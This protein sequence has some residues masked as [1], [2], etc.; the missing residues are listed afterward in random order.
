MAGVHFSGARIALENLRSHKLRTF[1]T[2]LGNIVGTM[3]VVAVVSLIFGADQ[4]ARRTVLD[5]GTD[6]F[7]IVRVNPI[8]FLTDFDEF[9][10]SLNNPNLTLDDRDW[11]R[12]RLTLARAVGASIETTADLRAGRANY[13]GCLVR[14]K[15]EDYVVLEDLPLALGRHLTTADLR[16]SRPVA[17]LGW[18]IARELFPRVADPVGREFRLQGR[19]FTV[20]GVVEDM[21]TVLGNN[22]NLFAVIPI[23]TWQKIFGS[24]QSIDIKVAVSDLERFEE[25]RDEATFQMRCATGCVRC[26]ATTSA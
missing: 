16:A 15:T 20:V 7:T 1:L 3:S 10:D 14:G 26:S 18:D 13:R 6:V 24:R 25:A 2:L 11:L 12:N 4:Y 9:L 5:E 22:R 23:T 21:G 17:V 19:H 8:N